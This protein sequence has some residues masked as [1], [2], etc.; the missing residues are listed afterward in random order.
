MFP[1]IPQS[2]VTETNEIEFLKI[3]FSLCCPRH[4]SLKA[5]L[6]RG[7]EENVMSSFQA[8]SIVTLE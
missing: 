6:R 8:I 1:L 2:F 3:E 4:P 5:L 7:K